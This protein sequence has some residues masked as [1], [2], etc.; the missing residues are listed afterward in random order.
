MRHSST[1]QLV[2]IHLTMSGWSEPISSRNSPSRSKRDH[3]AQRSQIDTESLVAALRKRGVTKMDGSLSELQSTIPHVTHQNGQICAQGHA[4][5][6]SQGGHGVA[7]TRSTP[8]ERAYVSACRVDR[9]TSTY[10]RRRVAN[11][12]HPH[13][14]FAERVRA[15]EES[16]P[17]FFDCGSSTRFRSWRR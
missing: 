13:T 1:M 7:W 16:H 3:L 11:E 17:P 8:S 2:S 12:M 6:I 5:C 14:V 4:M 15:S 9:Q 10:D